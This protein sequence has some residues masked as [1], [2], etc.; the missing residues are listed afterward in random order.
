VIS[1]LPDEVIANARAIGDTLTSGA[2]AVCLRLHPLAA[3][4]YAKELAEALR[5]G[6]DARSALDNMGHTGQRTFSQYVD[7]EPLKRSLATH[8]ARA[9]AT[10]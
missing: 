3:A 6:L 9:R 7:N 8:L 1:G 10:Q 5:R 2:E 4:P